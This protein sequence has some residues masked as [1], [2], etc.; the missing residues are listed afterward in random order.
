MNSEIESKLQGVAAAYRRERDEALRSKSLASERLKLVHLEADAARKSVTDLQTKL[1]NLKKQS[2]NDALEEING[3]KLKVQDLSHQVDF[4]HNALVS[5]RDKV[6]SLTA[7]QLVHENKRQNATN[8]LQMTMLGRREKLTVL[9]TQ[10]NPFMNP[11]PMLL[12]E[13]LQ[14]DQDNHLL[15][16]WEHIVAAKAHA[17]ADATNTLEESIAVKE[18]IVAGYKAHFDLLVNNNIAPVAALQQVSI[19]QH[20]Q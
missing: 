6:K 11:S 19:E 10:Q 8:K 12:Q 20:Q 15:S 3:I 2:G 1:Q 13:E 16:K 4:Q 18:R 17:I 5:M 14:S 9:L 7:E